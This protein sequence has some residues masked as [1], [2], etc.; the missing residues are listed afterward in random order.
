MATKA[1]GFRPV[2]RAATDHAVTGLAVLATTLVV[3]PLI[4]IFIYLLIKGA[5]S[6]NLDFFKIGRAHV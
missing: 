2:W 4:A 6:L 3:V 5:S 1:A